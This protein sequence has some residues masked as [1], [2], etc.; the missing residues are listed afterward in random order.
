MRKRLSLLMAAAMMAFTLQTAM[1]AEDVDEN[2]DEMEYSIE[3]SGRPGR[4][5][6]PRDHERGRHVPYARH[7]RPGEWLGGPGRGPGKHPD[8]RMDKGM[9]GMMSPR[10][11]D[12]LNL[13][14]AQKNQMVDLLTQ[15]FR[16]RLLARMEMADAQKKL[17]DI[18]E[19]E[20]PDH[21]AIIAA[22]GAMGTLKGK[23]DVQRRK[24]RD[25]M[26]KILTPEQVEKLDNM[27][28]G[29]PPPRGW[30]KRDDGKRPPRG[31]M[32][33]KPGSKPAKD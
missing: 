19:S 10:M 7:D 21:D 20:T 11:M 15:N 6:S 22:N 2:V 4:R 33:P 28:K 24:L 17:R 30:D 18:H 31:P 23:L 12:E 27:R 3:D 8:M 5:F 25:D 26:R 32:P 16:E 13:T 29:P 9:Q 14:D 1:A